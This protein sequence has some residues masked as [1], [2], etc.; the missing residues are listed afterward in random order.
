MGNDPFI[1]I[2]ICI[3]GVIIILLMLSYHIGEINSRLT[4]LETSIQKQVNQ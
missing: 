3:V 2:L 4:I 1:P